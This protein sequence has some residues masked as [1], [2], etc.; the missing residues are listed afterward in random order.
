[1]SPPAPPA[2]TVR[3]EGAERTF[4]AGNDVV[5]GRDLRADVRVAH[6]LISRTHLIVRYDQ[7]RWVAVDNGSLNGLYANNRRVPVIDI[8]DGMRVN[9]GN[10][11][12]PALTFE[13][14]RHQGSAGRPP[15]TTSIPIV[16][17]PGAPLVGAPQSPSG[18]QTS[19]QPQQPAS[20]SFRHP[21]HPP[22]TTQP[23]HSPSGP[24]A[25]QPP[26][27]PTPSH[28][29]G[30][31]TRFPTSG[32]LAAPPSASQPAPQIYRAPS[33]V[34]AAPPT[35]AQPAAS[36]TGRIGGDSSN[37]A[38]SMMKILRPG[39]A[40]LESTPGAITIGR[41]NDNDIVIP[42]VLASRHHATLIPAPGGTEIH[43]NRSINGT[44]VNGARVDS[45]VLHDGDVVTI[46]NIDL[47][48]AGGTLARRDQTATATRTGGLDVRGVTWTIENNKTLLDNISLT[49]LP[50]TL[51]AIIGPSGAG[52]STFARLVAGY[53]HPSTGTVAFE[54]HNVHAEYASLRSRIGMVPQDDVVHG[55]LTVQ[56]AL[57]YAA[58]LRLPPDTTKD[59]RAQVVARVLEELEMTQHL[60][61][62]VDKLSGGQRKRASVALEL[63]TGPSLL[64]LDEPTSGLDPALDRQ[65]MTMLRQL[66]DAGRVVLVVTHSL[67]YLDV[68]D[69]VLLLAPGGKTAFCGP[70]GQIGPAMGTTNWADIF[71]TVANDPDGSRERYLARTGPPPAPPPAEKPAE[72]GDPSHTSLFRQFSTIA[73]RQMR[74][75]VSDRGYFVFLALLPFIMGSLSMS[76]P[77]DVG[78][79]IPNPMGAAPNEPGQILVLLN[80]GAVFMGTALTIR[81]LIG[82]RAIFLREQAVG[83][84]TSAYLL[85]KVCVYTVFAIVQSAIVTIIAVLGK[86]AP[87]QGAVALGKPGLELFVDVA[88]TC[89]A[90]AM[91]GLALSAVAKSNEQIMPLLVVAVMSQLVF[92][93]GMI[94]VTGRVGLDQMAWATPARWGFAASASTADLTKLVPG[95]LT[96]KDSHWQHTPARWWFDVG[97]LAL[98][99]AVY[100]GFVRWKI[101]LKGG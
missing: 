13:V 86:G 1:M 60:H 83:L 5:I 67:T 40:G 17:T 100:L 70:P 27:G 56:Q 29:S 80:V 75:I 36:Q 54:G 73:R 21:A 89:V 44:F 53:T 101:R 68:C 64:I 42:E 97:M 14:G 15:L 8:Q 41:A 35:T 87:T 25:S 26:S 91:L 93:G 76:V 55:Q 24:L 51:T 22:T 43:D 71:S 28:P 38:T 3:Y 4:A 85:A 98:I 88:L 10:P 78:F 57:M 46:G 30:P 58:E 11:D 39:R 20:A 9:V 74:L 23:S 94:P 95:P 63:L 61:T 16:S 99:S 19:V 7:G 52:K 82:E 47:V 12:G 81:D 59:D 72:L 6:P 92:S 96:P 84:S 65:V 2:L 45:A 69:Q 90:S 34:H 48:F 62:R 18:T 50:G 77:G 32:P 33:A 66:A 49:A 79:G 31:Q 37:I